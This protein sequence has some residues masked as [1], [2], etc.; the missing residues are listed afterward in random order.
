M[1]NDIIC[2]FHLFHN[3]QNCI[4]IH[5]QLKF[6]VHL[7]RISCSNTNLILNSNYFGQLEN[8]NNYLFFYQ[9]Y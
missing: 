9:N 6:Y 1:N 5:D 2:K 3:N 7:Y 8:L 4:Y